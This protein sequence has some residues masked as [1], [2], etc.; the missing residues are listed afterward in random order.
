MMEKTSDVALIF[1]NAYKFDHRNAM[2]VSL[3]RTGS[4]VLFSQLHYSP[5]EYYY[6]WYDSE[7]ETF[8]GHDKKDEKIGLFKIDSRFIDGPAVQAWQLAMINRR[9]QENDWNS[10]VITGSLAALVQG[11]EPEIDVGGNPYKVFLRQGM[12]IHRNDRKN[13][14]YF[15]KCTAIPETGERQL[16]FDLQ[17][18]KQVFPDW[19]I[20]CLPPHM[21]LVT[22]PQDKALNPVAYAQMKD[23][24]LTVYLKERLNTGPLAA[25]VEGL[26]ATRLP[27]MVRRNQIEQEMQGKLV[28][29]QKFLCSKPP[30]QKTSIKKGKH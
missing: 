9:S 4:N 25:K 3:E 20:T 22:L 15:D 12:L 14:I 2:L 13:I 29:P 16:Y 7:L 21:V 11:A 30:V 26:Q 5:E 24:K 1:G 23:Q 8:S 19:R 18:N 10:E 27:E 28:G 6:S 17:L